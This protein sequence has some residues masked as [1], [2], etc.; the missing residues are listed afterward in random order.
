MDFLSKKQ[1]INEGE[2]P[3]YY[4]K[5][6]H[7][8]IDSAEV[9]A[10]VQHE[11]EK[12]K[13]HSG[14]AS[15]ASIFSNRIFCGECG[16]IYGSKVWHSNDTYRRIIWRWNKKYEKKKETCKSPHLTEDEIKAA[17]VEAINQVIGNR[18]EIV[19]AY[20]DVIAALGDTTTQTTEIERLKTEEDALYEKMSQMVQENATTAQDQDEYNRRYN[21]LVSQ[22]ETVKE[23]MD[24]AKK[25][26]AEKA[27]KRHAPEAFQQEIME[28][29]HL[30][31]FDEGLFTGTVESVT[32]HRAEKRHKM[33]V[34]CFKDG[35]KITVMI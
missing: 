9:F 26:I 8:A 25:L 10:M 2:V 18:Q 5:N 3:R 23:K 1:K 11:I 19:D 34:F 22:Y 28:A 6:S 17:F 30:L 33:A 12:K 7:P 14:H 20:Q 24:R 27:G 16:A 21:A 29:D 32:I 31:K 15:A 35:T 13:H 4:V